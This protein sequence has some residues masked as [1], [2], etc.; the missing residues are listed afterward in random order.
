MILMGK[1]KISE[2]CV[3]ELEIYNSKDD[4]PQSSVIESSDYD[5]AVSKYSKDD[6]RYNFVSKY[7]EYFKDIYG[8]DIFNCKFE[9]PDN[10]SKFIN[11]YIYLWGA[12]PDINYRIED[13]NNNYKKVFYEILK[14]NKLS[15]ITETTYIQFFVKDIFK[16]MICHSSN[17]AWRDI[18]ND[19]KS[20][21][22]EVKSINY[23]NTFYIFINAD[24]FE[25]AVSDK[26][27]LNEI[28][29][30]CYE[31][32]KKYDID[33]VLEYSNFHIRVD[34]YKN[35]HEIGGQHYFNS[36]CMFNCHII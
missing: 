7:I 29:I 35:Y 12:D 9:R 5:F 32:A 31:A 1:E 4:E 2:K 36:D 19:I 28:R 13:K 33:N 26:N 18:N 24:N 8:V 11:F 23:W 21:F 22:P 20:K 15:G 30:Y 27:Y 25:K 6:F 16:T 34:N 10:D 17:C 14:N 3:Q